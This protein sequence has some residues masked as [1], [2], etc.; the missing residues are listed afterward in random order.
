[1]QYTNHKQEGIVMIKKLSVCIV[2]VSIMQ[3]SIVSAGTDLERQL[4]KIVTSEL[5][6]VSLQNLH[7][8]RSDDGVLIGGLLRNHGLRNQRSLGHVDLEFIDNMGNVINNKPVRLSTSHWRK[9]PSF[10]WFSFEVGSL[11]TES[12]A[13]R[14]KHHI[15]STMHDL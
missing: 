7:F 1:M 12:K 6:D 13:I 5:R 4:P 9:H 3:I 15:G 2:L 14:F 11:I 10:K 8:T